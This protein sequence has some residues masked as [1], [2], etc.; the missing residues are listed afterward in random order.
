MNDNRNIR[1]GVAKVPEA[2]ASET[3]KKLRRKLPTVPLSVGGLVD[4]KNRRIIHIAADAPGEYD[5]DNPRVDLYYNADNEVDKIV[6]AAAK[7]LTER[8]ALQ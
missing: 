5:P 6:K 2:E 7:K 3:L 1:E 4:R 8:F